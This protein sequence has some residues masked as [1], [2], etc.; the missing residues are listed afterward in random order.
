[1]DVSR[2]FEYLEK[3]RIVDVFR[4]R[5]TRNDSITGFIIECKY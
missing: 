5:L 4:D 1:M 2:L 3:D